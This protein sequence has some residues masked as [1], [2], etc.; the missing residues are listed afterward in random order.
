MDRLHIEFAKDGFDGIIVNPSEEPELHR[1][2]QDIKTA[3][4]KY[5]DY[6]EEQINYF[7]SRIYELRKNQSNNPA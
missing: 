3:T 6:P 2:L 1:F 4:H 7:A 5:G